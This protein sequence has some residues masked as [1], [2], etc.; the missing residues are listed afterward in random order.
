MPEHSAF[1]TCGEIFRL[2]EPRGESS[3]RFVTAVSAHKTVSFAAKPAR[4]LRRGCIT[5][6]I[7]SGSKPLRRYLL[8]RFT[9]RL[10]KKSP[11][12]HL[13][14]FL[15]FLAVEVRKS[16]KVVTGIIP[17][18]SPPA[19]SVRFAPTALCPGHAVAQS[20]RRQQRCSALSPCR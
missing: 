4:L 13:L 12:V 20:R 19:G 11:H 6:G 5:W 10:T 17:F 7:S 1:L 18:P 15:A 8:D 9:K 16:A 14:A 3:Q 2:Q